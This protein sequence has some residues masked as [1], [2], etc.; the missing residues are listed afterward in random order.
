[1]QLDQTLGLALNA[2]ARLRLL[3]IACGT[4][5]DLITNNRKLDAWLKSKDVRHTYLETPGAHTWLVW[6]RN[7]P[8]SHRCCS[9]EA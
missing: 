8:P 4:E 5:D 7:L 2:N 6:R 3:W 1:M 9:R